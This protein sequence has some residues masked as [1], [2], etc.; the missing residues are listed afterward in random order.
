VSN[1]PYV[2]VALYQ[3]KSGIEEAQFL[4]VS[5]E[6]T[7]VYRKLSGFVRRELMKSEDGKWVDLVYWQN[8]DLAKKAEPM[9]Y[10]DPT[11]ANVM[12][13]LDTETMIFTHA[14]PVRQDS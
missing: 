10:H 3:L 8:R 11:I 9:I 5:D 12:A 1:N 4:A 13:V 14:E 6:A 7:G 2:E